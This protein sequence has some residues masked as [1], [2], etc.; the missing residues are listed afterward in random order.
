MILAIIWMKWVRDN[1][2]LLEALP[3]LVHGTRMH[4]L[5]V[6]EYVTCAGA[7]GGGVTFKAKTKGGGVT[8]TGCI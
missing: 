3:H 7:G 6:L 1:S 4:I 5:S 2:V 8:Q